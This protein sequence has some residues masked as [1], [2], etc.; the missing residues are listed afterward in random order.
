MP[1]LGHYYLIALTVVFEDSLLLNYLKL[2]VDYLLSL[3]CSTF[4][5]FELDLD[6]LRSFVTE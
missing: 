2:V 1:V 5:L 6:S 3:D 4:A